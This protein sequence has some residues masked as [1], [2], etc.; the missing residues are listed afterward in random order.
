[1]QTIN[2]ELRKNEAVV[3]SAD[4][5]NTLIILPTTQYQEKLQDFTDNNNFQI[6]NADPTKTFKK[7]TRKVIN[8]S[9]NL[10]NPDS[11]WKYTNLNLSTPT[12]RGLV[13]IHIRDQ[14]IRQ[15][16][17]TP[18]LQ[19]SKTVHTQNTTTCSTTFH[20]P[21]EEHETLHT[22]I[23][24]DSVNPYFPICFTRHIQYVLQRPHQ[25]ISANSRRPSVTQYC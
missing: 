5:G 18:S 21:P 19:T 9:T 23:E 24:T 14:P 3:T 22:G 11:R 1:M 12:I 17:A 15:T 13:K 7:H 10:I 16:G 25:R 4:K 2:A 6:S 20:F 8:N